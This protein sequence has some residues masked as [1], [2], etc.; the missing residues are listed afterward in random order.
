[1]MLGALGPAR[2]AYFR[3]EATHIVIDG[4][5]RLIKA[6]AVQQTWAQSRSNHTHSAIV[7]TS[8]SLKQASAPCSHS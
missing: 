7:T 1:M 5:L 4:E 8:G 3:A 6:A 2:V